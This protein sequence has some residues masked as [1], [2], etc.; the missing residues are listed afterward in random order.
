MRFPRIV[1]PVISLL[2]F[3]GLLYPIRARN[4]ASVTQQGGDRIVIK[5]ITISGQKESYFES[6]NALI[7][8]PSYTKLSLGWTNCKLH[9]SGD[10]EPILITL[11]GSIIAESPISWQISADAQSGYNPLFLSFKQDM[12]GQGPSG[13]N[14]SI[15]LVWTISVNG[16]PFQPFIQLPDGRLICN[17]PTGQRSFQVRITGTPQ[18]HQA[19]GYYRLQLT[20]SLVPQL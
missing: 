12:F 1:F 6:P 17:F 13:Q 10:Y 5:K 8:Q 7:P 16:S 19:D 14:T 3:M 9:R 2:L 18:Y 20:Q 4:P 15:P 11:D